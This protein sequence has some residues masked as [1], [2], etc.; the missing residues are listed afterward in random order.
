M[1]RS[2]TSLLDLRNHS[3]RNGIPA[4]NPHLVTCN[5]QYFDIFVEKVTMPFGQYGSS[6]MPHTNAIPSLFTAGDT[7]IAAGI[8]WNHALT[9][10][11]ATHCDDRAVLSHEFGHEE[12]LGHTGFLE[13]GNGRRALEPD[14]E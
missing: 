8:V 12:G 11:D 2:T 14:C 10:A 3:A 5:C 7:K 4:R 13:L 1:A 9:C 6:G